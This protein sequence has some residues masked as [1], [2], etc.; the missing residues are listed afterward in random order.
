MNLVFMGTPDFAVPSLKKI[1]EARFP[2]SLVVTSPDK[3][4][5]SASDEPEPTPVKKA[6]QALGL[7]V[8][9]VEDLKSPEFEKAIRDAK[10]DAMV[11]VAFRILP[12]EIFTIAPTFNLHA[13]L[14][15]KYRG[16]APINWAIINGETTTGVTTFF[17][18]EKVDAGNV[19]LQKSLAIE[20]NEVATELAERLSELGAE[21]VAET[22][23]LMESGQYRLV[24]QDDAQ[25]TRAPK[26]TKENTRIDWTKPARQVFNFI[27]GLSERP[28]AWTTLD[29][30]QMKIY[31]AA[32]L[33]ETETGE[34]GKWIQAGEALY[35][36]CG[37]GLIEVLSLQLEGKKRMR[38][39]DFLRGYRA[40]GTERFV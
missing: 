4:R 8:L 9:E 19:I 23:R 18:Q 10:P 32:L 27:R 5:R 12:K 36:Q 6:A 15:P 20:P 22:L 31:R 17:L 11:V 30:K 13:S 29:G 39:S 21:A 38:A 25:A 37:A 28:T 33:S 14:L 3:P 26:L 35:V 34:A 24:Q 2:I 1:V 40:R 16:A 7:R